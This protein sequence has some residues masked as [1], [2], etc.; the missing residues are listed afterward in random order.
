MRALLV[1]VAFLA[2]AAPAAADPQADLDAARAAWE[3]RDLDDYDFRVARSCFCPPR[4]TRPRDV[5][6]RDSRPVSGARKIRRY[7]TVERIFGLIQDAIDENAERID[8]SYGPGGFPRDV[9]I[10][11]SFMI[12]DEE[13]GITARKLRR[14]R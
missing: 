9:Y 8:T 1:L 7:A 10:D 6:V 5:K 3:A 11:Y 2:P 4:Y 12:A 13:L 14:R